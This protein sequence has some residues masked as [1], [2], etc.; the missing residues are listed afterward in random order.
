MYFNC[1]KNTCTEATDVA[2]SRIKTYITG[3]TSN[4]LKWY[5]VTGLA[6]YRPWDGDGMFLN[7]IYAVPRT[8]NLYPGDTKFARLA[9]DFTD[10]SVFELIGDLY[11]S[12]CES[13]GY[14]TF[15]LGTKMHNYMGVDNTYGLRAKSDD[16]STQVYDLAPDIDA[17][18]V[19]TIYTCMITDEGDSHLVIFTDNSEVPAICFYN[20]HSGP[21]PHSANWTFC[22][23]NGEETINDSTHI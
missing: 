7:S 1:Y 22:D 15:M 3:N 16:D 20:Y 5:S 11:P 17:F 9:Y 10:G 21:Y 2:N 8:G 19:S 18:E 12:C 14:M 4:T 6:M 23:A 13:F